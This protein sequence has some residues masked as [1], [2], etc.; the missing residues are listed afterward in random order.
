MTKKKLFK[1]VALIFL[2]AVIL[3]P[4]VFIN[5]GSTK[6]Q[7]YYSGD[8]ISYRGQLIFG[9]ANSGYLEIFKLNGNDV[10]LLV[11]VKDYNPTFNSYND[12]S[13]LRFS[14]EN[15]NLYVYAISQYTVFKY[16]FSELNSL[17]LVNKVKNNYWE[18]YKEIE[19]LGDSLVLISDKGV[20]VING[21]LDVIDSYNFT[22]VEPY[23]VTSNGANDK[24]L[25][26]GDSKIKIFDRSSRQVTKEISLNFISD[27]KNH[28]VYLDV[29]NNKIYAI[30]DYYAKKFDATTGQ[31][32]ASFQHL[33]AA[34]YGMESTVGNDY[35]YFS[36]GLGVVKLNKDKFT[37]ADFVY[38]TMSGGPQGWAIGL[39]LVNTDKGDILVVFNSSNII[40]LDGKLDKIAS[41]KAIEDMDEKP[42]EGLYL[43]LNHRSATVGGVV[44]LT[45]GGFWANDQLKIFIGATEIKTTNADKNGR[46]DTSLTIPDVRKE[47]QDIKVKGF[48]SGLTYS[49]SFEV[50]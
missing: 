41:V 2:A 13:D 15:G 46:F 19:K 22:G 29:L 18:W 48:N 8:A 30:D 50:K 5:S 11:K 27:N 25:A 12:Y 16:D 42:Q 9:T 17:A 26:V 43:N 37:V 1:R 34:G 24:I 35:V 14:S 7:P 32:L 23:S 38:T 4:L 20:K 3:T 49:I 39:K 21:N 6:I 31:L 40:L 33:D 36:N 44:N 47:K 10:D 45:G 28:K